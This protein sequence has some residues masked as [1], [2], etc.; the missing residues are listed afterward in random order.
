MK[1][2]TISTLDDGYRE[3]AETEVANLKALREKGEVCYEASKLLSAPYHVSFD[4]CSSI[5]CHFLGVCPNIY[6]PTVQSESQPIRAE[7]P[8]G[9][10]VFRGQSGLIVTHPPGWQ[11]Q[12]R[13]AGAFL[14]YRLGPGGAATALAMVSPMQRI[15]GKALGVVQGVGQIFPDLFPKVKISRAGFFPKIPKWLWRKCN[16][17][18]KAFPSKEW[19]CVLRRT[20]A[21][22]FTRLP[23]ATSTWLQDEP[24]MK[25]ILSRFFYSGETGSGGGGS[26]PLPQMVPWN[27]LREGAFTCPVPAGWQVEGG[28]TRVAPLDKRL[29][30][31]AI[32]PDKK[33][34]VRIGD[35]F[36][37]SFAA[38]GPD[39]AVCRSK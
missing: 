29:E 37:P 10:T 21:E 16:M 15:D 22:F 35:D 14:T 28:V 38:P 25:Q 23:A 36:I 8:P 4:S 13:G 30:I 31:L 19:S 26:S 39:D 32:S 33:V 24:V 18:R 20:T 7:I 11:V 9:W 27:D 1:T 2:M 12:E 5:P 3:A 17:H 34:L 6:Q